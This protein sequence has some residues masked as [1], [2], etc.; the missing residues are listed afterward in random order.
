VNQSSIISSWTPNLAIVATPFVYVP[1]ATDPF[2]ITAPDG[3][4]ACYGEAYVLSSTTQFFID[5]PMTD[6]FFN[7]GTI[8]FTSGANV[9]LTGIV[10]NWAEGIATAAN[11]F[12]NIPA[13]GD[14]CTLTTAIANTQSTCTGYNNTINFGGEDMIPIPETAY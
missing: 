3:S 4:V 2:T 1:R 5:L 6:G 10:S 11:A 12:P 14:A 13:V 7:G 8:E 9:G